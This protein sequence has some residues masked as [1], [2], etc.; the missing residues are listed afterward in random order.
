MPLAPVTQHWAVAVVGKVQITVV[1]TPLAG[2]A[3]ASAA[4]TDLLVRWKTYWMPG[5][6][7]RPPG[8]AGDTVITRLTLAPSDDIHVKTSLMSPIATGAGASE[9]ESIWSA[10]WPDPASR[11][12]QLT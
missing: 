9:S 6:K 4:A 7:D 10:A 1:V 11:S 5:P 3:T 12:A 2:L 8:S